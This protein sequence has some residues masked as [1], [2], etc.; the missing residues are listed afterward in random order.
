MSDDK[1]IIFGIFYVVWVIA[2]V[3]SVYRDINKN[4]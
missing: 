1:L 2:A 3:W 4:K